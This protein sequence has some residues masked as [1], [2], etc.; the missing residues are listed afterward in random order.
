MLSIIIT[1]HLLVGLQRLAFTL[2]QQFMSEAI[3]CVVKALC[4]TAKTTVIKVALESACV[5]AIRH[6]AELSVTLDLDFRTLFQ[7]FKLLHS[8][9]G[10]CVALFIEELWL[11]TLLGCLLLFG[12]HLLVLGRRRSDVGLTNPW[13]QFQVVV[14]LGVV[15]WLAI[16]DGFAFVKRKIFVSQMTDDCSKCFD[17]HCCG[18]FGT[19]SFVRLQ[20]Q[21]G[22]S[23]VK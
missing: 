8:L 14:G 11:W 2:G 21:S 19:Q 18:Q 16:P 22:G 5:V 7:S 6:H 10:D 12:E 20:A 4:A 9:S 15:C 17:G 3:G 1:L 13:W 23:K